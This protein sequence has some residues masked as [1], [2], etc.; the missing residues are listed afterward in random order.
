MGP[1]AKIVSTVRG[2]IAAWPAAVCAARDAIPRQE[3]KT[4]ENN[5]AVV[6]VKENSSW[7]GAQ[8]NFSGCGR[9]HNESGRAPFC[10]VQGHFSLH[11][12]DK[13]P[14]MGTLLLVGPSS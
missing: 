3:A 14:S 11:L 5:E 1:W 6:R 7:S 2:F 9:W 8:H 12:S 4:I 10:V 13:H